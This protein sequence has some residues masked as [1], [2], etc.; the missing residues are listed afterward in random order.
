MSTPCDAP[1]K[2]AR[3]RRP[4]VRRAPAAVTAS[5]AVLALAACG[6]PA[7]E[8]NGTG[9]IQVVEAWARAI[10]DLEA[11]GA[12]RATA[13]YITLANT[14]TEPDRLT[15]AT[16]DVAQ[17]IEIHRTQ[18]EDGVMRMRQVE[19]GVVLE[20]GETAEMRP[21]GLHVMLVGVTRSLHPG[22]RFTLD[23][24]L[25]RAGRLPVEVEVRER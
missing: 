12:R 23:L 5:L 3:A 16:G 24:E 7:P 17:A 25:E 1:R 2:A 10:G 19:G 8:A 20:P 9:D 21:G 6:D 4:H 22:D 14:G 13:A 15:A 18:V 11:T